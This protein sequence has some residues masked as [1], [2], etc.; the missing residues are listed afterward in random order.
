[1]SE[2]ATW[3]ERPERPDVRTCPR[4]EFRLAERMSPTAVAA[5]PELAT[6]DGASGSTLFGAVRDRSELL[7][8]LE[9]FDLLGLTLL[10]VH[11]LPD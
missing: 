8:I 5:F 2:P 1:M 11:R 6:A 7:S 3:S 4:Y 10:D 9:R